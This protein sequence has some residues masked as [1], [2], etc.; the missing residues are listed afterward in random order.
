M[1]PD[2]LLFSRLCENI[3]AY[4]EALMIFLKRQT[5]VEKN[6]GESGVEDEKEGE[7]GV[8]DEKEGEKGVADDKEGT[9]G[10]FEYDYCPEKSKELENILLKIFQ[11]HLLTSDRICHAQFT[12][13]F[14]ASKS[15]Q[16]F[17]KYIF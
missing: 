4:M 3:D 1:K 7:E 2:Y 17:F 6:K 11:S 10:V 12:I 5:C 16:S 8:A 14:L 9:E 13:F 15:V